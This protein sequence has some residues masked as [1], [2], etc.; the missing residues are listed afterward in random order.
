MA[1]LE[2]IDSHSLKR[3]DV[4]TFDEIEAPN[5][6]Y[7]SITDIK[8]CKTGKHGSAKVM[9]KVTNIKDGKKN[10]FTLSGS[11]SINKAFPSKSIFNLVDASGEEVYASPMGNDNDV[12]PLDISETSAESIETLRTKA[13]ECEDGK[14]LQFVRMEYPGFS[15]F[16]DMQFK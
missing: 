8:S 5:K 10:E 12:N 16:T 14:S 9:I 1:K 13:E 6:T 7:Y 2:Q 4:I 11:N 15:Y 3:G